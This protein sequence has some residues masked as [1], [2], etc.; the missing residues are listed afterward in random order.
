M[1]SREIPL[2][3]QLLSLPEVCFVKFEKPHKVQVWVRGEFAHDALAAHGNILKIICLLQLILVALTYRIPWNI[4]AQ[5]STRH[6][7]SVQQ[8]KVVQIPHANRPIETARDEDIAS[9]GH[10]DSTH[11]TAM[12]SDAVSLEGKK[13][14]TN[15]LE[16]SLYAHLK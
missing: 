1:V 13:P 12:M 5:Y 8:G 15:Y 10:H 11:W 14:Y 2:R 16:K 3:N 4:N 9:S 7:H 6:L